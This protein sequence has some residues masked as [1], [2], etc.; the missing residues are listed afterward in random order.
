VHFSQAKG[1]ALSC[2]SLQHITDPNSI[3]NLRNL[4]ELERKFI[5]KLSS[6]KTTTIR[7][8]VEIEVW[9]NKF[10]TWHETI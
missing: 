9:K 2:K 8:E 6:F 7:D 5:Q 4:L 1:C 3:F 10:K